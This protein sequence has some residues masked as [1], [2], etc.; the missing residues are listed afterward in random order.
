V[1][2]SDFPTEQR[3]SAL[4]GAHAKLALRLEQG[5]YRSEGPTAEAQF[6]LC[7]DLARQLVNYCA[8]KL[9]QEAVASEQAAL[10]RALEGLRAKHWCSDAQNLWVIKRAATLLGWS[11][12]SCEILRAREVTYSIRATD[13]VRPPATGARP[14]SMVEKLIARNRPR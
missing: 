5:R 7:E 12:P 9:N 4:A 6:E 13:S 11:P 3:Y 8:R 2:P 1:I 14:L 10:A